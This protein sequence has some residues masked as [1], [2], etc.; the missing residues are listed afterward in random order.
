[1]VRRRFYS[2]SATAAR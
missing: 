1:M 2:K